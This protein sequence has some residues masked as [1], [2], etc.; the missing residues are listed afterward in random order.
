MAK[1]GDH[2]ILVADGVPQSSAT[3]CPAHSIVG[4]PG[5]PL[6]WMLS[7]R[8]TY[9]ALR[10]KYRP[11]FDHLGWQAVQRVTRDAG[12]AAQTTPIERTER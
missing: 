11:A 1:K 3:H 9:V 12:G 5:S 10:G 7:R 2:H 4:S 6:F 8:C